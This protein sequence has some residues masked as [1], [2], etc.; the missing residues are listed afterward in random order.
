MWKKESFKGLPEDKRFSFSPKK[1]FNGYRTAAEWFSFRTGKKIPLKPK[2]KVETPSTGSG[3][4]L[5]EKIGENVEFYSSYGEKLWKMP[6]KSYPRTS[7]QGNLSLLISGDNNQVITVDKNGAKIGI[8]KMDG[9]FLSDYAFSNNTEGAFIVFAG[10]ELF[11]IN[12]KAEPL[13]QL[14]AGNDK[15]LYFFKSAALSP[16]MNFSAVHFLYKD[17]DYFRLMNNKGEKVYDVKFPRVYP[18]KIFM[19]VSDEGYSLIN[20]PERIIFVSSEGKVIQDIKKQSKTP[21]VFQTAFYTG[22]MF[23]ANASGELGFYDKTGKLLNKHYI[24]DT[25][26]RALPSGK[27]DVVFLES[28]SYLFTFQLIE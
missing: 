25:P 12:S 14:F 27:E 7:R 8:E 4:L 9:R 2:E 21:T 13:F 20:L 5:Y 6:F 1:S 23:V 22:K 28:R 19:A 18:H 15:E 26:F 11:L 17:S 16:N 24:F 3:Y 10:G